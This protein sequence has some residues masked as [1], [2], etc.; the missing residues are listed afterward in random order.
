MKINRYILALAAVIICV[1]GVRAQVSDA[2]SLPNPNAGNPTNYVY[3]PSGVLTPAT[4]AEVNGMLQSLREQTTAEGV[5]AIIPSIG[6]DTIEEYATSLFA[7][8]GVGKKDKDNGV[9]LVV[10]LE[11]HRVRIET[12]YGTEGVL[13]DAVCSS[14]IRNDF[15]PAMKEGNINAAVI[16]SVQ[17]ICGAMTD[18]SVL[19][20]LRS[21]QAE[22]AGESAITDS[23]MM[24][25]LGF[26]V[27]IAFLLT[28][29]MFVVQL[30][31]NKKLDR[32]QQ[33]LKW[34][35]NMPAYWIGAVLSAGSG[36]VFALPALILLRRARNGKHKCRVCGAKMHKLSEEED[37]TRLSHSQDFE[38]QLGTVD[39]DVW[40]CPECGAQEIYSFP[41]KQTKYVRC[42]QCGTVAMYQAEDVTLVPP[43]TRRTGMGRKRY[44]CKYCGHRHD[45]DYI[46]PRRED[47]AA[48]ALAAGALLGASGRGGGGGGFGGGF[49]GGMSGGGGASGSW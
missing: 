45:K 6:D 4:V 34:Q 15:T 37:N 30:S 35:Q 33:V 29:A 18:P 26:V 20:E 43:S 42:P 40:D 28:G 47:G 32:Y 31:G 9:L 12:G 3:D 48:A 19:E 14:I 22:G 21:S 13:T 44:V 7:H 16:R 46:I 23:D 39:Y 5:V 24:M 17:T 10:A 41:E 11:E 8:W 49:G 1:I 25:F 36:L 38:E 2:E 27:L